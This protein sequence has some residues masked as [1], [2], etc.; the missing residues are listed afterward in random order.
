VHHLSRKGLQSRRTQRVYRQL[1][2][3]QHGSL[4]RHLA[5]RVVRLVYV[6][7]E[8]FGRLITL[9]YAVDP[10]LQVVVVVGEDLVGVVV[11]QWLES[12][13]L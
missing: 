11:H 13:G 2:V 5:E 9:F 4:D 7:C 8:Q 3:L 6:S 10:D 1:H 12:R